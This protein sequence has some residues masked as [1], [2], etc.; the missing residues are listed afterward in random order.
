MLPSAGNTPCEI[1]TVCVAFGQIYIKLL[2]LKYPN[3]IIR[4]RNPY[5]TIIVRLYTQQLS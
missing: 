2:I 5:N 1:S 4:K 3:F